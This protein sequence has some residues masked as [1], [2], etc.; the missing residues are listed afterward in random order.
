MIEL[1][2]FLGQ[3]ISHNIT[4]DVF[5]GDEFVIRYLTCF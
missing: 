4:M 2:R 3:A 5:N 1:V